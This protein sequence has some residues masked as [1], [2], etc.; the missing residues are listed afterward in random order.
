MPNTKKQPS[1]PATSGLILDIN[2]WTIFRWNISPRTRHKNSVPSSLTDLLIRVGPD[3]E[4]VLSIT[5]DQ[6]LDRAF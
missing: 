3:G 5:N 4:P 2:Q 1:R 6:P